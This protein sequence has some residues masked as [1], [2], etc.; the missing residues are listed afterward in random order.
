MI[1]STRKLSPSSSDETE[2]SANLDAAGDLWRY[3]H[4]WTS[5]M[6]GPMDTLPCPRS[7][8]KTLALAVALALYPV[9]PTDH[10]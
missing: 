7:R 6:T 8:V 3:G 4:T 9:P 2:R 1:S 5:D 10:A